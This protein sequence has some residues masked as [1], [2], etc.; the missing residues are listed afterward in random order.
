[1]D[2]IIEKATELGVT[3]FHPLLTDHTEVRKIKTERLEAQIIEA[4]EQ[5]ERINIP[6]LHKMVALST[7]T[8]FPPKDIKLLA[9]LERHDGVFIDQALQDATQSIGFIIGPVGGFSE[10]ENA[11][12]L[13]C[14]PITAISLGSDILRAETASLFCLAKAKVT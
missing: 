6:A 8:A 2:F 1:M 14:E 12:M 13:A 7:I 4:A 5:C 9:C 3:D 11:K 10:K